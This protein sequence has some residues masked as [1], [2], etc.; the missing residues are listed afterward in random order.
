[1]T[2][3]FLSYPPASG[4]PPTNLLVLLHGWGADAQDL[5]SLAPLLNLPDYQ[6]LCPNAPFAHPQIPTGKAWYALEREDYQGLET[7]RQ[8]LRD[9]LTSL[10]ST[11]NIPL[12]RTIVAGFSQGGAM[13]YDVGLSLPCAGLCVFSGYLHSNPELTDLPPGVLIVHG[14]QD[15]V[16]PLTAARQARAQLQELGVLVEYHELPMGHEITGTVLDLMQQFIKARM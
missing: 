11:T 10:E 6:I 3:E 9:W 7:S 2:L 16:V 5:G 15:P 13:T 12:D 1:M 8:L 4:N 14:N